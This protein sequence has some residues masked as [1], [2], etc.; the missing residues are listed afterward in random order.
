[1]K[2]FAINETE[3]V[4]ANTKEEAIEHEGL[5]P[6]EVVSI[7]E[8]LDNEWDDEIEYSDE[9]SDEIKTITIRELM[10]DANKKGVP[11]K[12]MSEDY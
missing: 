7:E 12:I 5:E 9:D 2:L 3:W 1:M 8:I 6:E 10:V 4:A 11:T